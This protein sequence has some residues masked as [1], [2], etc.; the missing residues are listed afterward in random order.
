MSVICVQVMV[1]SEAANKDFVANVRDYDLSK[2]HLDPAQTLSF[3][4]GRSAQSLSSLSSSTSHKRHRS[5]RS[6]SASHDPFPSSLNG[7]GSSSKRRK[8]E[9]TP[10]LAEHMTRLGLDD[11]SSTETAVSFTFGAGLL[12]PP[13]PM[14]RPTSSGFGMVVDSDSIKG[15]AQGAHAS[16]GW[17]GWAPLELYGIMKNGDIYKICPFLPSKA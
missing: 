9:A 16:A 1:K 6:V 15:E 10:G 13:Q 4:P 2:D 11:E 12:Q 3:L 14:V 8:R 5:S 17:N 7:G